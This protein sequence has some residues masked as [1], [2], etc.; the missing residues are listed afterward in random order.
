M[1]LDIKRNIVGF[2]IPR[3]RS[4]PRFQRGLHRIRERIRQEEEVQLVN[5]ARWGDIHLGQ[6]GMFGGVQ[7]YYDPFRGWRWW[8]TDRDFNAVFTMPS[9]S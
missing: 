9:P 4:K 1:S 6:N 3:K 2:L 5:A 7:V 8:Y